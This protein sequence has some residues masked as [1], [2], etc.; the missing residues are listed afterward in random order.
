MKYII[1]LASILFLSLSMGC[2]VNESI[3]EEPITLDSQIE[4]AGKTQ[5]KV[6][7]IVGGDIEFTNNKTNNLCLSDLIFI[8][9][10]TQL[11]E[12]LDK[13]GSPDEIANMFGNFPTIIYALS[14]GGKFVYVGPNNYGYVAYEDFVIVLFPKPNNSLIDLIV[15]EE[16]CTEIYYLE[17]V[18]QE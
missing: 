2:S 18:K 14:D 7:D 5:A 13:I 12:V 8:N 6:T 11:K 4:I 16:N 3:E 10:E 17:K 9:H 1:I 15:E